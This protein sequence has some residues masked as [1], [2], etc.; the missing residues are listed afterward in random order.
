MSLLEDNWLMRPLIDLG[1]SCIM[2]GGWLDE[3][4]HLVVCRL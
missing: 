1:S 3:V 4:R 2:E